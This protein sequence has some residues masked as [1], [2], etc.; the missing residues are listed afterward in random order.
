MVTSG[1]L[2]SWR[3]LGDVIHIGT[4]KTVFLFQFSSQI[5]KHSSSYYEWG[6]IGLKQILKKKITT[7][8]W[9]MWCEIEPR[10][11]LIDIIPTQ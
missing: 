1:M 7:K 4:W 5:K 2:I 8:I 11:L 9:W 6:E 3:V 10:M